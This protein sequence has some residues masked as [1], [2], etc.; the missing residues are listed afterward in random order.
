MVKVIIAVIAA[1]SVSACLF[2]KKEE[3]TEPAATEQTA[4]AGE[5]APADAQPEAPAPAE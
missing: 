4:P 2:S 5:P 1:L 3:T